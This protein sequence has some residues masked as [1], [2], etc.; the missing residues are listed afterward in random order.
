MI[1]IKFVH[2]NLIAHDWEKLAQFYIDV[3]DCEPV[4]PERNLSGD[5]IDKLTNIPGA[6]VRGIHLRLPGYDNGPTLEI[7][8][9]NKIADQNNLPIVN[10]PGFSHIAFHVNDVEKTLKRLIKHGGK[11]CGE[12]IEKEIEGIGVLTAVYAKDPE[13]NI[14]EIQNWR[15][16][17]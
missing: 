15:K 4:Y 11:S 3:F 13:G 9:Y 14:V 5:W 8:E 1:K 17:N 2:T 16:N 6:E 12:L 10:D 7:F